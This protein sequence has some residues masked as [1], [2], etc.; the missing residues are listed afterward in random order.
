MDLV[1]EQGRWLESAVRKVPRGTLQWQGVPR[2]LYIATVGSEYVLATIRH[3]LYQPQWV[4]TPR[5]GSSPRRR[6]PGSRPQLVPAP[7]AMSA[8]YR[9]R[10]V[11]EPRSPHPR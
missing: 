6:R 9:A 10:V 5:R 4:P 11:V 8:R 3:A 2:R 7:D 1:R